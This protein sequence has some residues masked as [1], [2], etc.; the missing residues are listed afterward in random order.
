MLCQILLHLAR[1]LQEHGAVLTMCPPRCS[2][3]KYHK[4]RITPSQSSRISVSCEVNQRHPGYRL[5]DAV[6]ARKRGAV[7]AET[8]GAADKPSTISS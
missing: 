3:D 6:Y 2:S 5:L 1:Q 8:L 4:G 7:M